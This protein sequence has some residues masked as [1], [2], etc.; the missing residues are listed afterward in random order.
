MSS[1]HQCMVGNAE[2]FGSDE[3]LVLMQERSDEFKKNNARRL[4]H[5]LRCQSRN[6]LS[7]CSIWPSRGL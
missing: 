7:H 2:V 4:N 6:G 3:K 1:A 5:R